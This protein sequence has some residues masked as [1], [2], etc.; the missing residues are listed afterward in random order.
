MSKKTF[1]ENIDSVIDDWK[2][3]SFTFSHQDYVP[4]L[5][6]DGNLTYGNGENKRGIEMNTCVLFV[7]IRN[8]VALT[9]KR[10]IRTMGKIY[11][12]FTHCVL[13]AAQEEGGYVRNIIGDR[14]MIVFPE[15]DCYTHA[16]DCA[17][18]INQIA[19][20][21]NDKFANVD[22]KCG[23]GIDYGTM[24]VMKVGIVVRGEENDDNKG[25]VWIGYPANYAS[26]LTD[27]ANK[28]MKED[29]YHVEGLGYQFSLRTPG[30]IGKIPQR[31][32]QDYSQEELLTNLTIRGNNL[33]LNLFSSISSVDKRTRTFD[34]KP[35]L[36]SEAVYKGFKA[37]NPDRPSI[38]KSL[39]TIQ[40][41][42]IRDI[43]FTVYGGNV[44]WILN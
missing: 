19:D 17:I 7:D 12:V 6:P 25:L 26:R 20:H 1:F 23:I 14:V 44:V 39:W 34:F 33:G 13:M 24:N 36:M 18:T 42:K 31:K 2:N 29:Y 11:S 22:F 10:Q 4:G 32:S 28:H 3:T 41:W 8:S 35:I 37:A 15:D 5:D 9:E 21:I 40:N 43:N 30:L 27:S 38:K 16:V